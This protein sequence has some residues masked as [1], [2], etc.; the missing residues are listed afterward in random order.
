MSRNLLVKTAAVALALSGCVSLTPP[1]SDQMPD[2]GENG[3][4][5]SGAKDAHRRAIRRLRSSR[6][7]DSYAGAWPSMDVS[8]EGNVID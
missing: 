8:A 1:R 6:G 3:G 4:G 2:G 7:G 5:G